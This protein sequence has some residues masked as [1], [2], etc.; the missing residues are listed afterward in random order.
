MSSGP[1][2]MTVQQLVQIMDAEGKA[3]DFLE[4]YLMLLDQQD[5]TTIPLISELLNTGNE[6]GR[7]RVARVVRYKLGTQYNLHLSQ[8]KYGD[9]SKYRNPLFPKF[10][11]HL[12]RLWT[13][14]NMMDELG[15][16]ENL[17]NGGLY[18]DVS[19]VHKSYSRRV[20]KH[21]STGK[22]YWRGIIALTLSEPTEE[23]IRRKDTTVFIDWAAEHS[24]LS[25]V[26]GIA[27]ERGTIDVPTLDHL[28]HEQGSDTPLR[29]GIL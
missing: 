9:P 2:S 28:I 18:E 27:V 5:P 17:G 26:I 6:D 12:L 1:E 14:A 10:H 21:V 15:I 16:V 23:M 19:E 4:E 22:K 29:D 7:G 13:L 20:R 11:E 25:K 3:K 8:K 24:D